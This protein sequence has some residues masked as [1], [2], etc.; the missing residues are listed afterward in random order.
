MAATGTGALFDALGF[1]T[2]VVAT[3]LTVVS[4]VEYLRNAWPIL[5]GR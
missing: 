1:W 4:G 5:T 2:L 3:V